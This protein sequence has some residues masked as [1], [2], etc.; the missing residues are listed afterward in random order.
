MHTKESLIRDIRNMGIHPNDTV[1]IH[2]SMR[3]IGTVDGGADT[4]IDAFREVL[5]DGLFLV[6]T[7]T[8]AS[9][10]PSQP[11]YDVLSAVPCIGALPCAAA[12]REDGIRSLHPTHS[13]TAWGRNAAEFVRGEE[14]AMSPAPPGY[15]WSRLADVGAKILLIGVGHNRNTFIHAVDEIYDLPDRLSEKAFDV[16]IRDRNGNE[17]THPYHH[18]ACSRTDDVSRYFVNFEPAFEA[19][20]VQRHGVLGMA[21]VRIVDAAACRDTVLRIYRRAAEDDTRT[22]K[23]LCDRYLEIPA[24]YYL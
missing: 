17:M 11:V 14:T 5:T 7:H 12:R 20:G 2:T 15:A 16:T 6:P 13:M 3:A 23:E 18:H 22:D 19:C 10:T 24:S 8:W 21:D 1:L 4:V 9:V